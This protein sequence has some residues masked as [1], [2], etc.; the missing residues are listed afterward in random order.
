MQSDITIYYILTESCNCSCEFCIRQNMQIEKHMELTQALFYLN[1]LN[2]FYKD[3]S[4]VLTGGEPFLYPNIECIISESLKLFRNVAITTNGS[5]SKKNADMLK[6]YLA[7]GLKIQ[8]SIDGTKDVHNKIRGKDAYEKLINNISYLSKYSQSFSISTTVTKGNIENILFLAK[9]LNK[10]PFKFWKVSQE[11]LTDP[12]I[13][14]LID[15]SLWNS[16]VDKLVVISRRPVIVSKYFDFQLFD[17]FRDFAE[18]HERDIVRNCGFGLRK[19]YVS[20]NFDISP[21][22][23]T[24]IIVG[25]LNQNDLK[26]IYKRLNSLSDFSIKE[27]SACIK[28]KYLNLCHGGCPGYSLKVFGEF[29]KGDIRCPYVKE[30]VQ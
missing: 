26:T 24:D 25:N 17:K 22:S 2:D 3:S 16:M 1:K 28:C 4:I 15:N 20:P 14:K 13:D 30:K 23:C 8:F 6:T 7:R 12:C 21:C 5:F 11:Q 18:Q 19:L 10:V 9:E 29:G 27:D